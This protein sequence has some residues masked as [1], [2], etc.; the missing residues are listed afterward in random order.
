MGEEWG[1]YMIKIY[2]QLDMP[3]FDWY[4]WKASPF[5]KEKERRVDFGEKGGG[6][7]GGWEERKKEKLLSGFNI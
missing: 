2:L 3:C 4:A 5:L 6:L 1:V 7:G